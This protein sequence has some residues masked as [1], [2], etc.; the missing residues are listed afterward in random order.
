MDTNVYA[1]GILW[2]EDSQL[3]G[4]R[5]FLVG[6]PDTPTKRLLFSSRK[7]ARTACEARY[8]YI[9]QRADLRAEPHGWKM[10]KVVKVRIEFMVEQPR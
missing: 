2:R 5:E 10:P 9:S 3:D 6:D 4:Y 8:G 7:A 1:W